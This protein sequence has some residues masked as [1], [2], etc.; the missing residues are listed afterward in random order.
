MLDP[1]LIIVDL[2]SQEKRRNFT[3]LVTKRGQKFNLDEAKSRLKELRKYTLNNIDSLKQQF[4]STLSGFSGVQTF[5]ADKP[6]VAADYIRQVVGKRTTIAVNS[7]SVIGELRHSLEKIGYTLI[8]T[9]LNQFDQHKLS[10]KQLQYYWQLPSIS[11]EFAW[12]SFATDSNIPMQRQQRDGV[13]NY[14]ALLGVSAASVED[15]SVYFMQ[16]SSNIRTA[17]QEAGTL[18]LLVA[19][20]KIVSNNDDALFQTK[21]VGLF[22]MESVLLS[23]KSDGQVKERDNLENAGANIYPSEIHIIILDNGRSQIAHSDFSE[24]LTCIGCRACLAHCPTHDYFSDSP[25]NYPKQY[26]WSFLTESNKSLDLCIGC[27][28]CYTICPV[29]INIPRL[30]SVARQNYLPKF[31]RLTKKSIASNVGPLMRTVSTFSPVVNLFLHSRLAKFLT[32]RMGLGL[33]QEVL[34]SLKVHHRTFEQIQ[35]SKQLY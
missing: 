17:I 34:R 20:D 29:G 16:H 6:E 7:A 22:G 13:K 4:L 18:I 27:G 23:L 8:Y 3:R 5:Y 31:A 19:I 21:C 12:E 10:Q 1:S 28:M 9:Y 14:V 35:N 25:N 32:E 26:L 30:I 11:K 2:K 24:M 15:G 33:S